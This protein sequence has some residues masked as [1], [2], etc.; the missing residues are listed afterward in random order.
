M[1]VILKKKGTI[2]IGGLITFLTHAIKLDIKLAKLEPLP[3]RTLD[4][5]LMRHMRFC[6]V[7]REGGYHLM[8]RNHEIKSI[9][10][11]WPARTNV[12]QRPNW[13]YDLQD[14]PYTSPMSMDIPQNVNVD[15]DTNNEY[16]FLIP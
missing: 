11:P 2:S 8:I 7:K 14:P 9:I 15:A 3:P 4:L 16:D 10:L 6:K 12:R 5:N 13:I 1:S